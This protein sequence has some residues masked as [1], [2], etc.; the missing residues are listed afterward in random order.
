MAERGV[1]GCIDYEAEVA[2]EQYENEISS[3]ST[4]VGNTTQGT[5]DALKDLKGS[6]KDLSAKVKSLW[7]EI[8]KYDEHMGQSERNV[9]R[10]SIAQVREILKNTTK[11]LDAK[12]SSCT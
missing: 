5:C 7:K 1:V 6:Q 4:T 8:G 3:L 11:E 2:L 12:L 9:D 10:K